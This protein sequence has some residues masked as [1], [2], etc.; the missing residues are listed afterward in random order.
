VA[1]VVSLVGERVFH[2]L[3]RVILHRL[4]QRQRFFGVLHTVQ[5]LHHFLA[6]AVAPLQA[7]IDELGVRFLDMGGVRQHCAA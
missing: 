6:A 4:Q 7:F 3:G 5:R 1:G 2:L